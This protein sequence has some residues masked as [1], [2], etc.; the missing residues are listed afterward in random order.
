MLRNDRNLGHHESGRLPSSLRVAALPFALHVG[1]AR[2]SLV[3]LS[4]NGRSPRKVVLDPASVSCVPVSSLLSTSYLGSSG[5]ADSG[6]C[7]VVH[8]A[9]RH[10]DVQEVTSSCSLRDD[11]RVMFEISLGVGPIQN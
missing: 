6:R 1:V 10:V 5:L 7:H 11:V 9:C 3:R 4:S 8:F 2:C